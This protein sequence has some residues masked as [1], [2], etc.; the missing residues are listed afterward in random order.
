MTVQRERDL[1]FSLVE[2]T[3]ALGVASFCLLAVF[4][5]FPT[6]LRTNQNTVQQTIDTSWARAIAADLRATPNT[7][8][9]SV[10]YGIGIPAT[11]TATHT[12]FLQE[13]GT[14][15]AQDTDAV[16]SQNPKYRATISFTA[17]TNSSQKTAT[18]VRILL[19]WPALADKAAATTPSNYTGSYEAV[20]A[21]NRN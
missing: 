9:S 18:I 21:L 20:T 15:T 19:T 11:G 4:A 14:A 17:P 3:L 5:L 8:S 6:S 13:D 2:L 10:R 7:S 12:I 1:A 16:P